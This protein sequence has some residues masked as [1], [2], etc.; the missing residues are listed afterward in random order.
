VAVPVSSDITLSFSESIAL[1]TGSIVLKDV[2][3]NVVATYTAANSANLIV[4]GST[5][6]VHFSTALAASSGYSLELGA[7]SVHD[8]AGNNFAGSTGY[9]FTTAGSGITASASASA[10]NL[11]GTAG[12][13]TLIAG[14]GNGT[15]DGGAGNDV[16]LGGTG[17]TLM[18]GGSGNDTLISG[19]G[20]D[21]MQGG[22]GA[23]LYY[24]NDAGDVVVE[25]A[26]NA[27]QQVAPG[28][29]GDAGRSVDKVIAS[30]NYTLTAFVENLS[31]AS[32][33]G[34]LSGSGNELNNV[35]S[36]NESNNTLKG[37]FGNDTLDGG[38]GLDT[39]QYSGKF[40]D[41]KL[42]AGASTAAT[43]TLTDN[44]P[45]TPSP[46]T[47]G[48]DSLV[49]VER[50]QFSDVKVALDLGVGQAAGKTVLMMAVST[51]LGPAFVASQA[52]AGLFLGY[53]DSGASL[54]DGATLLV[55]SGIVAAFAG[56]ADNAS[57]VK[58]IYNNVYGKAPDAATLASLVAPLDNH[59]TTQAA[60]MADMAA[61][62]AN[63]VHVNLAGYAGAGL[64]YVA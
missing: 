43:S 15:L 50:L 10:P 24:V 5:L 6:T 33:A 21:T 7:S 49:N 16:L 4:S 3:G 57:F 55:S 17:Q 41:Y 34:A 28:P 37:G 27:A 42:V 39:A 13:D 63:Q 32:A 64:Q 40:S 48:A 20:A 62:S 47:D 22:D 54:L 30:I 35:L 29:Q 19:P 52:Y 59:S 31:L 44:R 60:W 58:L 46:S 53:F 36:G 2:D 18:L 23:D 56:G 51:S 1:G 38:G 9:H 45:L 61:S 25:T 14:P 8:L 11:S 12:D 26:A